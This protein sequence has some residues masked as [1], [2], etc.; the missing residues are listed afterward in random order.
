[1]YIR[2]GLNYVNV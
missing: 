2:I 1:M